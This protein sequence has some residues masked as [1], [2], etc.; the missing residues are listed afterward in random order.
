[1]ESATSQSSTASC[2]LTPYN[3]VWDNIQTGLHEKTS[4]VTAHGIKPT[5]IL[6]MPHHN[7]IL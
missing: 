2:E 5:C 3:S 4:T 7:E 1:M 6:L